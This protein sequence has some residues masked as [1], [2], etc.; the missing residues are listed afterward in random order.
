MDTLLKKEAML[1]PK[2]LAVSIGYIRQRVGGI[3]RQVVGLCEI[4]NEINNLAA[5]VLGGNLGANLAGTCRQAATPLQGGGNWREPGGEHV[6]LPKKV[7]VWVAGFGV[8]GGR[9]GQTD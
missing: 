3:W 4:S 6:R 9:S 2:V 8:V 7:A 1:P 5:F